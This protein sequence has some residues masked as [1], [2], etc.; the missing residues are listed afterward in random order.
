MKNVTQDEIRLTDEELAFLR[1]TCDIFFTPESPLYY[2]DQNDV[3]PSS[4]RNVARALTSKGILDPKTWQAD[5][6]VLARINT[7]SECDA[8]VMIVKRT[9]RR[10][11]RSTFYFREGLLV[12]YARDGRK[13]CFRTPRSEA[14]LVAELAQGLK[15]RPE[16]AGPCSFVFTSGEFLVFAIMARDF[17]TPTRAGEDRL[18]VAEVKAALDS[19]TDLPDGDLAFTSRQW[20]SQ[21]R[22]LLAK[23]YLVKNDQGQPA[24]GPPLTRIARGLSTRVQLSYLRQDFIDEEWLHRQLVLY[25]Q[26]DGTLEMGA[27]AD[28]CIKMVDLTPEWLAESLAGAVASL[29]DIAAP[30]DSAQG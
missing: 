7:V 23:E 8:R 18:S 25:P 16:R 20:T 21:Q 9:A 28:G 29:P 1:F 10:R 24:L 11:S 19:I 3:I 15:T 27:Q 26:S 30:F 2:I 14:S 5:E 17:R 6:R 13:H 4:F 22:S 12:K